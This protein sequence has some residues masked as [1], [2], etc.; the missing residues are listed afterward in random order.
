VY[1]KGKEWESVDTAIVTGGAHG[2]GRA[3]S[4]RFAREGYHVA[5]VDIDGPSGA[6]VVGDI[7]SEGR[8]ASLWT[9]DL[10]D[11]VAVEDTVSR[12]VAA[13]K[14]IEVLVSN[15][16]IIHRGTARTLS[17]AQ[18]EEQLRINLTGSY[19]ITRAVSEA[20]I[21]NGAGSI[22]HVGSITGIRGGTERVGYIA[23][24]A[25]VLAMSQS[26]ALDLAPYGIRVNAVAPGTVC[27]RLNRHILEDPSAGPGIAKRI[28]L[29]RVG[30]P[31]DV[32]GV[33]YFLCT[34]DAGYMTGS[35]V[36][37]DGGIT[38]SA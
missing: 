19:L 9:V 17:V 22:V 3:T 11:P 32:A 10:A 23:S 37:V 36:T 15:A 35:I 21:Q 33:I 31:E 38:A 7:E 34:P 29:G 16:A 2:I 18:W 20:M 4:M 27:T 13:R 24:K 1:V 28:P 6:R 26:M 25:G 14:T 5:L 12:V 30:Q 8:Q